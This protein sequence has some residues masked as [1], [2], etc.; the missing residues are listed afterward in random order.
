VAR[1]ESPAEAK[2]MVDL[3]TLQGLGPA[4][5]RSRLGDGSY[6][7]LYRR[8]DADTERLW[9]AAIAETRGLMEG[10]WA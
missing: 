4:A 5:I 2:P 6:G 7:G 10:G 9:Q 1:D 8:P 3:A